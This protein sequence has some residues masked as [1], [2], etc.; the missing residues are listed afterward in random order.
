MSFTFPL[1]W[2]A[3]PEF[4]MTVR[5]ARGAP[6]VLA[7]RFTLDQESGLPRLRRGVYLFGFTPGAW[8]WSLRLKDLGRVAPSELFSL[9]VT[10]DSEPEE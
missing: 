6:M 7:T 1:D 8:D 10:I 9:L 5:P 4:V 3:L 2:Q